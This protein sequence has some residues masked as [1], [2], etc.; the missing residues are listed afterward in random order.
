MQCINTTTYKER[1]ISLVL[2]QHWINNFFNNI[3]YVAKRIVISV[4]K[5]NLIKFSTL[6]YGKQEKNRRSRCTW[7]WLFDAC[8]F[9]SFIFVV[10]FFILLFPL[11]VFNLQSFL[12]FKC[13]ENVQFF[14]A[15]PKSINYHICR[16]EVRYWIRKKKNRTRMKTI[17]MN[18]VHVNTQ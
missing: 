4:L 10:F 17:K 11:H 6:S 15:E 1:K 9:Y 13:M 3:D 16:S 8:W 5:T 12:H 7:L 14:K 2:H 18:H